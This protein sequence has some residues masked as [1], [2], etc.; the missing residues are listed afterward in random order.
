MLFRKQAP[1]VIEEA[2]EPESYEEQEMV[3]NDDVDTV[4]GPSVTVEGD[5]ASEGNI[6]VKGNVV[7]SVHTSKHLSV[8]PGARILANV[9]ANSATVSG[10]IKGN[11]KAKESVE[12]T[13]TAKV[14]GDVEAKVLAIEAGALLYGKVSMPGFEVPEGRGRTGRSSSKRLEEAAMIGELS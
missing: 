10:E 3:V 11:I 7:G 12:L 5:F 13:A 8:E 1:A 14:L 6:I 9:R 2:V 4:V